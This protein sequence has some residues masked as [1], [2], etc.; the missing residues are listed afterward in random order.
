MICAA[1]SLLAVVLQDSNPA[2]APLP[3]THGDPSNSS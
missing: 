2:P 3:A 1:F